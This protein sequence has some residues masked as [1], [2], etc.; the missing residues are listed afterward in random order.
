MDETSAS[1]EAV[2]DAL[3]ELAAEVSR[4]Q[5]PEVAG[6]LQALEACL[7]LLQSRAAAALLQAG[8][9]ELRRGGIEARRLPRTRRGQGCRE[10]WAEADRILRGA[11]LDQGIVLR[12]SGRGHDL[13]SGRRR[14]WVLAGRNDPISRRERGCGESTH[15]HARAAKHPGHHGV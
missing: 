5:S 2:A 7:G 3:F 11:L 13:R 4:S 15:V 12:G 8:A 6:L 9:E 1:P 14:G 10:E